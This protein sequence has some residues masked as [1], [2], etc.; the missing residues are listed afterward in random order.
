MSPR[1]YR[2]DRR[3]AA[4]DETRRRIVQA[5]VDLHAEHGVTGTSY[6]MIARRADVAI[7]T[8][9]NHF[10]TRPDLITACTGHVAALAPPPGPQLLQDLPDAEARLRALARGLFAYYRYAERWLR[11]AQHEVA[12]V[13]ELADFLQRANEERR[14]L[15][16]LALE[17][18]VGK[19]VPAT[20]AALCDLL[21]DFPAWL[22][23]VSDPALSR[24]AGQAEAI[25]GD[26]LTGLVRDHVPAQPAGRHHAARRTASTPASRRSS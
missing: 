21:L 12:F 19:R 6:A 15:I 22:R 26:A 5:T 8:V 7:P 16:A 18:A 20:L 25:V 23:L 3:L 2:P 24:E 1:R 17:P 9:Y 4:R 14:G 10:P 13:P 11:W